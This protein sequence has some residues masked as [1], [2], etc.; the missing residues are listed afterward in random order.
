MSHACLS[1]HEHAIGRIH[2]LLSRLGMCMHAECGRVCVPCLRTREDVDDVRREVQIMHH[3]KGHPNIVT[4]VGAFEDK[5]AVHLVGS[6]CLFSQPAEA[7]MCLHVP[8]MVRPGCSSDASYR[9]MLHMLC[10]TLANF[11]HQSG[12]GHALGK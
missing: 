2:L 9:S 7:Y 10:G 6:V 12:R 8:S 11:G 5:H 4:L 1:L 3:L